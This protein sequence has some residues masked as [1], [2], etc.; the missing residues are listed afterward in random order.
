MYLYE[1]TDYHVHTRKKVPWT[2]YATKSFTV[3]D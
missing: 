2:L 3:H 1:C